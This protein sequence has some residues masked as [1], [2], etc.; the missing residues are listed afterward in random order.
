MSRKLLVIVGLFASLA[1]LTDSCLATRRRRRKANT[2]SSMQRNV[3][4][5]SEGCLRKA[6]NRAFGCGRCKRA[7]KAV[8]QYASKH[9]EKILGLAS[10]TVIGI[11]GLYATYLAANILNDKIENF[12]HFWE[13]RELYAQLAAWERNQMEALCRVSQGCNSPADIYREIR[14]AKLRGDI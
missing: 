9:H 7:G 11:G 2:N 14:L 3:E 8:A 10:L 1:I 4:V 13:H 5:A 6:F 12:I